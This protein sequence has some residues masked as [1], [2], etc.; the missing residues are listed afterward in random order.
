MDIGI[1]NGYSSTLHYKGNC[2]WRITIS[3]AGIIE[4]REVSVGSQRG[5]VGDGDTNRF[6]L[7]CVS[8]GTVQLNA[9]ILT[10]SEGE[11]CGS[12]SSYIT[13]DSVIQTLMLSPHPRTYLWTLRQGFW[14]GVMPSIHI[15]Y[16]L[17]SG[18][19]MK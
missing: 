7:K 19:L 18:S 15:F 13:N 1:L 6:T 8:E 10:H 4:D 17:T 14:T 16:H 9:V 11:I 2:S 3:T 5:L 12:E